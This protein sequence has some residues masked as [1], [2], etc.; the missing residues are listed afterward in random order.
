MRPASRSSACRRGARG[1][2]ER[3]DERLDA[4]ER[5]QLDDQPLEALTLVVRFF[6]GRRRV[7]PDLQ[8]RPEVA[9]QLDAI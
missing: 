4:I 3:G 2:P 6:L 5:E 8:Q 1:P 9:H 7:E